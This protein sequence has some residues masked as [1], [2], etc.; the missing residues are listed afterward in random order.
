VALNGEGG[1]EAFAGYDRYKKHRLARYCHALPASIR[2]LAGAT[3]GGL[4]PSG[5]P[6]T[7]VLP[8]LARF[9]SQD[10]QPLDRL[11]GQWLHHFDDAQALDL[12]TDDFLAHR[13]EADPA[14]VLAAL[15]A[16]ANASDPINAMLSVDARSYL[17][18]DLLVKVDMMTMAHSMEGRSPFLDHEFAG[19]VAGIPGRLKLKGSSSKWILKRALRSIVPADVLNRPKMGFGIPLDDWLR[20]GVRQLLCDTLQDQRARER[21]YFKADSL[22]KL[23]DQHLSGERNHGFSLWNIFV[24]EL[25]HR[26]V[27]DSF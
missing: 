15:F 4:A 9:L 21:G 3:L 25:W 2:K 27:L 16:S 11:Y 6:E 10:D 13:G 22:D 7:H 17:P 26:E 20:S 8:R 14:G 18:D 1:D 5:L 19:F 23:L 24:L 12:C